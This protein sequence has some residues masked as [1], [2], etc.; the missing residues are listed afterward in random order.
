MTT[1]RIRYE[2]NKGMNFIRLVN[3]LVS[4]EIMNLEQAVPVIKQFHSGEDISLD[5]PDA[6]VDDFKYQVNSMGCVYE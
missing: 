1:F 6:S 5:I 4:Y 2:V 3:F